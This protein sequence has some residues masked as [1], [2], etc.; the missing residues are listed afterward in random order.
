M[1]STTKLTA[2]SVRTTIFATLLDISNNGLTFLDAAAN[3]F[4]LFQ[5]KGNA[6]ENQYIFPVSPTVGAPFFQ[7]SPPYA[8]FLIYINGQVGEIANSIDMNFRQI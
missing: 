6:A 2:G 7:P 4:N 8:S 3:N 5:I 1:L